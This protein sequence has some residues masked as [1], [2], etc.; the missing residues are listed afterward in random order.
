MIDLRDMN[1]IEIDAAAENRLGRAPAPPP[2]RSPRRCR[3]HG[4][5]LGFGDTASVGVGGITLGG[6]VGYLVRKLGLT[7]DSSSPP[8]W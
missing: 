2:A 7:I 4:L 8:N 5:I 1:K 3:Q 6:G